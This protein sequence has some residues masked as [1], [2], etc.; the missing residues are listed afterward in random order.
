MVKEIY[1]ISELTLDDFY[2]EEMNETF[3]AHNPENIL[4]MKEEGIGIELTITDTK[5]ESDIQK[6]I[7]K[8]KS[9]GEVLEKYDIIIGTAIMNIVERFIEPCATEVVMVFFRHF[10]LMIPPEKQNEIDEKCSIYYQ[11]VFQNVKSI[12]DVIES[13]EHLEENCTEEQ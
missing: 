9:F 5:G 7:L 3:I 8:G 2:S 13:F 6:Y 1:D 10:R 12:D 4:D 11:K